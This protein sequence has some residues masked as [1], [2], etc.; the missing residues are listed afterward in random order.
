MAVLPWVYSLISTDS[1]LF[2]FAMRENIC[3]VLRLQWTWREIFEGG[4]IGPL[5]QCWFIISIRCL[6][7]WLQAKL[8]DALSSSL[9]RARFCLL[10]GSLCVL[11]STTSY[12]HKHIPWR[13]DVQKLRPHRW[14]G[15]AGVCIIHSHN[16][17][18]L[19]FTLWSPFFAIKWP[20]LSSCWVANLSLSL[21]ASSNLPVFCRLPSVLVTHTH[22]LRK[23]SSKW[24]VA[25]GFSQL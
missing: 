24:M 10:C 2:S 4:W 12:P 16:R 19:D 21:A 1:Q 5:I 17:V 13:N 8:W 3:F 9:L 20:S 15:D 14:I 23:Q 11:F 7:I 25:N 22:Q 6:W 18:H